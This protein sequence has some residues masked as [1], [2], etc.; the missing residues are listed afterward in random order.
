MSAPSQTVSLLTAIPALL[1]VVVGLVLL[2][3]LATR[4]LGQRLVSRLGAGATTR[5]AVEERLVLD[6]RRRVVL[7]RVD[8]SRSVLLLIGG[9]GADAVLGWIE[10]RA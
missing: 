7:V 4:G 3:R 1:A 6:T 2:Q 9:P 5:L 10:D 8:G